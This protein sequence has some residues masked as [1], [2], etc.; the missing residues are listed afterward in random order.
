MHITGKRYERR[1]G[2]TARIKIYSNASEV[3]LYQNGKLV[4]TQ[5]AEKIFVFRIQL[6]A[7]NELLA[8]TQGSQDSCVFYQV[9]K[10]DPSYKLQ[11]KSNGLSWEKTRS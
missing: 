9:D 8:M 11:V 5:K 4:G 1:C 10:Q 3:S 7:K 6:E 2:K